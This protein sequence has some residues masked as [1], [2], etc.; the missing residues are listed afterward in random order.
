MNI[1]PEHIKTKKRIGTLDDEP[2]IHIETTGGLHL[3]VSNK[4]GKPDILG[5]GPHPA[6]ARHIA[7][8]REKD[9]VL[10]ELSKSD[11]VDQ[12]AVESMVPKYSELTDY[13]NT[14]L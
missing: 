5:S 6:V 7:Q 4:K 1:T 3:I 10:T 12:N 11:Q 8:K 13:L 2:V 14:L 9:L